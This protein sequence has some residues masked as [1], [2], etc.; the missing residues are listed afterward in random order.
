MSVYIGKCVRV[1]IVCRELT[2]SAQVC[3]VESSSSFSLSPF[4]PA[5][6]SSGS[7]CSDD[8]KYSDAEFTQ[9]LRRTGAMSVGRKAIDTAIGCV[10]LPLTMPVI[11]TVSSGGTYE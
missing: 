6:T 2:V 9:N 1:Y 8:E 3:V 4:S 7:C 5:V 11:G 10:I